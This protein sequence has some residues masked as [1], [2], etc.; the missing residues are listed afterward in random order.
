MTR[1]VRYVFPLLAA[2]FLLLHGNRVEAATQVTSWS[3]DPPTVLTNI[4][5]DIERDGPRDEIII[6]LR[7][8]IEEHP[9]SE[10]TDEAILRLA[11][12]HLASDDI[13]KAR[14]LFQRI[15]KD[16]PFSTFK[17]EALYGLA[18]CQFR[19][20][21]LKGAGSNLRS[22]LA[23][24]ELTVLLRAK[25]ELL[26][27]DITSIFAAEERGDA[28][29]RGATI[30]VLL[31][32][33][34]KYGSFGEGALKG[35]LL[36]AG[37]FGK[38]EAYEVYVKDTSLNPGASARA[39]E[40]LASNPKVV[41]IIGP[42][43][44]ST[45]LKAAKKAQSEEMPIIALSQR[46][47]LPRIGSYVF[48]N[49]L[50][51]QQQVAGIAGFALNVLDQK[52]FVIL[53][54]DNPYGRGLARRF[55]EEVQ[56]MGGEVLR[57]GSYV[58]GKTDFGSELKE[59]FGIEETERLEGRRKIKEYRRTVPADAIYIPDYYDTIALIAPQIAYYDIKDVTMLGSN[60]W[61]SPRLVKVGGGYVEG[62][63][64]VDGFFA[65]SRR[66]AASEFVA[67]F[68]GVYGEE[69]G[70]IEAQAYDSVRM[71]IE[72]LKKGDMRKRRVREEL[73]ALSDFEG[74]TG[75]I[76]FDGDGEAEKDVFLLTVRGGR[77]VE[78]D[79]VDKLPVRWEE[80]EVEAL[81]F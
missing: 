73:R 7:G 17:A 72:T 60:G 50:T 34:G 67:Q 61:N 71:L 25:V 55:R 4:L 26:L 42:L 62:A 45:A 51:P 79:S 8:F 32:L 70:I 52:R 22:L 48:R 28:G 1:H 36:A 78:L 41:G 10:V 24:Y 16:F 23:N 40:E 39:V 38:G 68:R 35:V 54:P 6:N 66:N 59:L 64:F 65:G 33:Q 53:H 5:K 80:E 31:P 49:F 76:S 63:Y 75:V 27:A 9:K 2:L 20:G 21:E 12:I 13:G 3:L 14:S 15:L 74:A 43:L 47:G 58:A 30:G 81:P 19:D 56:G 46:D 11:G 69:P 29:E 77:I 37:V 18:Y 44:S 57:E